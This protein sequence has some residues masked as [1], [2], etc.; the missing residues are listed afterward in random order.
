MSN[1]GQHSAPAYKTTASVIRSANFGVFLHARLVVPL[2]VDTIDGNLKGISPGGAISN[3]NATV[4]Y[5]LK[6]VTYKAY[7][8]LR[9]SVGTL[10][11]E[12]AG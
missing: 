5:V 9:C 10:A 2:D 11:R 6:R 1:D 12:Y 8:Q 4:K 7:V 3:V